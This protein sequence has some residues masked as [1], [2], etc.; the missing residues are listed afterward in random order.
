[1]SYLG[2]MKTGGN[3]AGRLPMGQKELLRGKL[4]EQV[5]AGQI[6]LKEAAVK[7]KICYRQAGRIKAAY[8]K[9]G[10]KA[11]IHGNYGKRSNR[12]T[13][14]DTLKK[15]VELYEQKYPDFG[16]TFAA[17]KLKE[18]D[19]V[20][21]G[22]DVLRRALLEA[23]L[24]KRKRRRSEYRSRRDRRPCFGEL[25]QFD[26]CHHDWFEG[27]GAKCCLMNLVD[28]ARGITYAHLFEQE[29]TVAAFESFTQWIK[30]YGI[31]QAVYCD[32]KNAFISG[33]EPTV[34]E[35]LAGIEPRSHFE[36]ACDKLGI[37]VIPAN[38]PQAKGRVERNHQ[39]YQDRLI[40]ELRLANI[41]TIDQANKF[42]DEVYLPKINTKFAKPAA[43]PSDA[44]VPL[45]NKDLSE[46]FCFEHERVVSHDYVISFENHLFQILKEN[47]IL[48]Q[49]KNKVII[50]VRLDNSLD[51]YFRTKGHLHRLLVEEIENKN[52]VVLLFGKTSVVG[53]F[54]CAKN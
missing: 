10:D 33:R 12:K 46:I 23:G 52:K 22:H 16:P 24:W 54:N 7:L 1:M 39:V 35:Q 38:S 18:V 34:D 48:P 51:I 4:M 45:L 2:K 31:P 53:H 49:P 13:D 32:R 44:H 19:G 8:R 11:L 17:E 40:K 29:T 5:T 30:R 15:A 9:G 37:E 21:I 41:S 20:T 43:D 14:E 50:R 27:R 42:L 25:I 47:K 6:T 28:D 36:K 26:G 3:M